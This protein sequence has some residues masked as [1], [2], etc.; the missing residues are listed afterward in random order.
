MTRRIGF[1]GAATPAGY[2]PQL[3][4]PRQGLGDLGW[5]EG[6]NL[7]AKQATKTIPAGT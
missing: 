5:I 4:A 2:A 1:L 3:W 6:K 7:A